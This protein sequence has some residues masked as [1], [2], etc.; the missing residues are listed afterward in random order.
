MAKGFTPNVTKGSMQSVA[1]RIKSLSEQSATVPVLS[2][3]YDK[4]SSSITCL[5]SV[6]GSA[7]NFCI[8]FQG[9]IIAP[10]FTV[11]LTV[12]S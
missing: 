4:A 3:I 11:M 7:S 12:I 5:A 6:E 2:A 1:P 10:Y 8:V 9:F